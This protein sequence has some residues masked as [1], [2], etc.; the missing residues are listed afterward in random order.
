MAVD[1]NV[2]GIS[3]L[4]VGGARALPQLSEPR[5]DLSHHYIIIALSNNDNNDDNS[6]AH[7]RLVMTR[8]LC[9][10]SYLSPLFSEFI[11]P[12]CHLTDKE[13]EAQGKGLPG[14]TDLGSARS[15]IESI[16]AR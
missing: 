16:N 12:T 11:F 10:L 14:R 2:S 1:R 7:C 8:E 13:P 15:S 6:H 5:R 4:A 3:G 9:R